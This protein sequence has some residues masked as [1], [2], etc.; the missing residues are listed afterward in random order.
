MNAKASAVFGQ[1][2]VIED[3]HRS[4]VLQA[5]KY[6]E[7][8]LLGEKSLHHIPGIKHDLSGFFQVLEIMKND[9]PFFKAEDLYADNRSRIGLCEE[10]YLARQTT[11]MAMDK[12]FSGWSPCAGCH[13]R[14]K[15]IEF[16]QNFLRMESRTPFETGMLSVLLVKLSHVVG[17]LPRY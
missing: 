13:S 8:S 6:S 4:A 3:D 12:V 9:N 5:L 7:A 16:I 10:R 1:P 17:S 14:E 11:W 15:R 2:I